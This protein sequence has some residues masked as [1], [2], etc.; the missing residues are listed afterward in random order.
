MVCLLLLGEACRAVF[1]E[2]ISEVEKPFTFVFLQSLWQKR[3]FF[4]SCFKVRFISWGLPAADGGDVNP[5]RVPTSEHVKSS[6]RGAEEWCHELWGGRLLFISSYHHFLFHLIL[7]IISHTHTHTL[8]S[9]LFVKV[10]F[11]HFVRRCWRCVL[12]LVVGFFSHSNVSL[13]VAC[14]NHTVVTLHWIAGGAVMG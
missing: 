8:V 13:T 9:P 6:P 4:S 5:P 7:Q 14:D 2:E 11:S 12:A 1:H 3:F 10:C